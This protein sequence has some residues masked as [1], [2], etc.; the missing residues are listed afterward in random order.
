MKKFLPYIF[1]LLSNLCFGSF[2]VQN[3]LYNDTI[4]ERKKETRE[5][6][7]KRIQKQLFGNDDDL[8]QQSINQYESKKKVKKNLSKWRKINPIFRFLIIIVGLAL[9]LFIGALISLAIN[10]PSFSIDLDD[11]SND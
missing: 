6:Y 11:L 7:Q 8:Y 2:P 1:I 3:N 5:E 9:V 10:P 4:I